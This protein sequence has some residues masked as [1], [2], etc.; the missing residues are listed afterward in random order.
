M[1]KPGIVKIGD[2]EYKTVA[3]R[4]NEFRDSTI[5][6]GWSIMTEIVKIDDEQCVIK[7]QIITSDNKIVATGHAQEFRKASR[8]NG[9]SYLEVCETSSIGRALAVL[10]LSGSEFASADEVINA[11]HQQK[12]PILQQTT[13]DDIE[14]VI[15]EINK[16]D[17]VD[18]L[19]GIYKEAS[20]K[21]DKVSL[22]KLKTYLTDRKNELEA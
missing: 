1:I 21:F 22:A 9:T 8:L 4:V 10:G 13:Q 6:K 7:T 17:S 15:K 16:A 5:Y 14:S 12:N 11:M 2:K 18:E 19:M 3:Y 20:T